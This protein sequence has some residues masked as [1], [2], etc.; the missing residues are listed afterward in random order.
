MIT[1]FHISI[2]L[3]L[4]AC[5]VMEVSAIA[6]FQLEYNGFPGRLFVIVGIP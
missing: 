3:L 5:I 1:V 6:F 4:L 2:M